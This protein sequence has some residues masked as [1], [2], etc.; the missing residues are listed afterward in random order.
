M[1]A[2]RIDSHGLHFKQQGQAVPLAPRFASMPELSRVVSIFSWRDPR[3]C[4]GRV[5]VVLEAAAEPFTFNGRLSPAAARDLGA[6][7]LRAAD[8]AELVQEQLDAK[9]AKPAKAVAP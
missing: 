2:P 8:E 1:S 7:L 9:P 4:S 5:H 6:N 3:V